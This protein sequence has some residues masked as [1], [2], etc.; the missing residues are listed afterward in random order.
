MSVEVRPATPDRWS[1]V[2]S[3]FGRRGADPSWCWCQRFIHPVGRDS[4]ALE[5]PP[6]TNRDGLRDEIAHAAVPPGLIAYVDGQ[7]AG[8]TRVGPRSGLPGVT[9]N[10]ALA[11][12]LTEDPRAWWVTCFVV[13]VRHRRAGVGS[14]LLRAAVDFARHH[15]ATAVEGHPVD[16]AGLSAANVGASAIFTGTMA[17]FSAAGFTEVARTYPTRP[18]M[19]LSVRPQD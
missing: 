12:V 8:W 16:A 3:V 4:A 2:V 6:T 18:V 17:M 5:S 13:D 19:R 10:R 1:D 11:R 9:G 14:A 7:P 15:G